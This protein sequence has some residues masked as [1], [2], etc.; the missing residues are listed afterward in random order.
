M[1]PSTSSGSR[2]GRRAD[3]AELPVGAPQQLQGAAVVAER[4]AFVGGGLE[5][6]G[7]HRAGRYG[8]G[9]RGGGLGRLL[10]L[11]QQGGAAAQPPQRDQVLRQ[12]APQVGVGAADPLLGRRA[13][14]QLHGVQQVL[15]HPLV[16]EAGDQ[17]AGPL[18]RGGRQADARPCVRA[19]FVL[20]RH[21]ALQHP[22]GDLGEGLRRL[23]GDRVLARRAPPPR[24][25]PGPPQA[26]AASATRS[27]GPSV[28]WVMASAG[29]LGPLLPKRCSTYS[30]QCLSTS[31]ASSLPS[32]PSSTSRTPAANSYQ[33][34]SRVVLGRERG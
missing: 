23:G 28:S 5:H 21:E 22:G 8:A 18:H 19:P 3:G 31:S 6:P 2:P 25:P 24:R 10:R 14:Q 15:H 13:A 17:G 12:L 29:K 30:E 26:T 32:G 20:Q 33:R 11:A 27:L 34:W 1:T 7:A 16:G 4:G 9:V